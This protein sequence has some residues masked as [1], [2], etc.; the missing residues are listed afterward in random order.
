MSISSRV[1]EKYGE[2]MTVGQTHTRGFIWLID[3]T[4]TYET[5]PLPAG[6]KSSIS[7]GLITSLETVER[8]MSV[9][10]AGREY[11]ILRAEPVRIRGD[12]SHCECLLVPKGGSEDA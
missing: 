3:K 12:F 5:E 4:R 2:S 9:S 10:C 6:L 11:E 7:Y 1:I 8:G